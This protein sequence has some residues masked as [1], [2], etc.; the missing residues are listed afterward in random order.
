MLKNFKDFLPYWKKISWQ[1]LF[2]QWRILLP[3]IFFFT[4]D[5]FYRRLI[6]T[7]EYSYRHFFYKRE[8]LVFSYL[9]I[10][11]VYLFHFKFD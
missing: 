3:T 2:C 6:F 7:D 11:L 4:K 10:S 8:H 5:Y 9:K 1:N